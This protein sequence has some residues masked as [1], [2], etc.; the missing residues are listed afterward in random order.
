MKKKK[1]SLRFK[2]NVNANFK[3]KTNKN[4]NYWK[5]D[6]QLSVQNLPETD[7]FIQL[8][9]PETLPLVQPQ[10]HCIRRPK[11]RRIDYETPTQTLCTCVR[12][13]VT[14]PRQTGKT[15][16]LKMKT[17]KRRLECSDENNFFVFVLFFCIFCLF[18]FFCNFF[19]FLQP[20]TL[21]DAY[22][23]DYH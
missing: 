5:I 15:L 2:T 10:L 19:F 14:P 17:T 7:E 11:Y 6:R 12:V 23:S 1:N 21:F 20:V 9:L 3:F 16:N 13:F 8:I 22:L 4:I 18:V